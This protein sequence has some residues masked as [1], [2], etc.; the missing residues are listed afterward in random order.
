MLSVDTELSMSDQVR[1]LDLPVHSRGMHQEEGPNTSNPPK[2]LEVAKL[3]RK[4]V[5]SHER[6]T[7]RPV[8]LRSNSMVIFVRTYV[9]TYVE[10]KPAG[11]CHQRM[12]TDI[13]IVLKSEMSAR[14]VRPL[15]D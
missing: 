8:Q 2:S 11:S 7:F 4:A 6:C 14:S 5:R 3:L 9:R 1:S 12:A 10:I 15:S 13:L